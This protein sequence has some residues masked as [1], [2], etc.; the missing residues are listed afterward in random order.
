MIESWSLVVSLVPREFR[1]GQAPN[2]AEMAEIIYSWPNTR[3]CSIE[4]VVAHASDLDQFFQEQFGEAPEAIVVFE[5]WD[6]ALFECLPSCSAKIVLITEDLHLRPLSLL[7]AAVHVSSLVLARFNTIENLLGEKL[8]HVVS[9]PLHCSTI[10]LNEPNPGSK[11]II[12]HFGNLETYPPNVDPSRAP[13][14]NQYAYRKDWHVILKEKAAK[15]YNHIRLPPDELRQAMLQSTFG[16]SCTYFPYSFLEECA[17]QQGEEWA[18]INRPHDASKSYLVAKFLEIPGSG[19]LMLADPTGVEDF[20]MEAGF[21][22]RRNYLAISPD[23]VEETLEYIFDN[24]NAAQ[25]LEIRK[26]G[27]ELVQ[28]R[29]TLEMRK[30]EYI[31]HLTSLL[32]G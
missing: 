5:P 14:A 6:R 1:V 26:N 25:I 22:D 31:G 15:R 23:K 27:Y 7:K 2:F 4:D 17:V 19:L 32:N 12:I 3:Y 30:H 29:H 28:K 10:F 13:E 8:P 16:F 20:L 21:V 9:F 18:R 11:D 24:K